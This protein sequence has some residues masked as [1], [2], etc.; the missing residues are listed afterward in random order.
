MSSLN[1]CY[2]ATLFVVRCTKN[3][4]AAITFGI[5]S[6]TSGYQQD[7]GN[8]PQ[9][10]TLDLHSGDTTYAVLHRSNLVDKNSAVYCK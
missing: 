4:V 7:V 6:R 9:G 8:F 2:L 5:L 10:N 3:A 1:I